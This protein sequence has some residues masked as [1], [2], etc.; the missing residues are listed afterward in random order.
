MKNPCRSPFYDRVTLL[1]IIHPKYLGI[2][3]TTHDHLKA[4]L[5]IGGNVVRIVE[6]MEI[7]VR[8]QHP[9]DMLLPVTAIM[10]ILQRLVNVM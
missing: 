10:I 2:D 9:Y 7:M 5:G 3:I 1:H 4:A 6:D 8:I